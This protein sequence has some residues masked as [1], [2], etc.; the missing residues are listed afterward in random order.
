MI[1]TR[2]LHTN[3]TKLILASGSPRRHEIL[4]RVTSNFSVVPS[5]IDE[6]IEGSPEERVVRL[7]KAKAEAVSMHHHGLVVGADTIVVVDGQILAKPRSREQGRSM[8]RLLSGRSHQVLTGLCVIRTE[9][10]YVK[11][12]CEKTEVW[13][14][15]ITEQE[16][17]YYLDSKEYLDKAGGYAIQGIAASFI[18]K[19]HGDYYN[20][21]GLPLCRLVLLLREAGLDLLFQA[22]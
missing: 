4:S 7:A 11:T 10:S 16:I 14:R 20:V 9:D 22:G 21:M 5:H 13:F 6:E 15:D 1:S 3:P 19:I 2:P 17:S 12:C 18:S 8:L